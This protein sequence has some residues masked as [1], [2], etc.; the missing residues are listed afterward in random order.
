MASMRMLA[1]HSMLGK[2]EVAANPPGKANIP[3]PSIVLATPKM[4]SAK[5]DPGVRVSSFTFSVLLL[6]SSSIG[7]E[8]SEEV[9][10]T[11]SFSE[12]RACKDGTE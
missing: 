9:L 8:E 2:S 10:V 11:S 5:L 7:P 4:Q 12:A 1:G 3:V 6:F